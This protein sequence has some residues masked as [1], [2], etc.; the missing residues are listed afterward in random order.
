MNSHAFDVLSHLGTFDRASH[1]GF[2]YYKYDN[3]IYIF[4]LIT[5]NDSIS[6][7]QISSELKA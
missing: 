7:K 5:G 1:L 4:V 3:V 6:P 2:H